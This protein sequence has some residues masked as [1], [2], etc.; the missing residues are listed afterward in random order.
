MTTE[1]TAE[2]D[3]GVF[4]MFSEMFAI[5]GEEAAAAHAAAGESAALGRFVEETEHFVPPSFAPSP[6]ETRLE[7][8]V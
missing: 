4:S 3:L 7:I 8:H 5:C 1:T 2:A 6:G